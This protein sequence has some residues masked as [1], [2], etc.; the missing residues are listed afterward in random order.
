MFHHTSS[1]T[2]ARK[3]LGGLILPRSNSQ[4]QLLPQRGRGELGPGKKEDVRGG[5]SMRKPT[6]CQLCQVVQCSKCHCGFL[7]CSTGPELRNGAGSS[8]LTG[9]PH[10][11]LLISFLA[12]PKTLGFPHST[13][14]SATWCQWCTLGKEGLGQ[15]EHAQPSGSLQKGAG[16]LRSLPGSL[17]SPRKIFWLFPPSRQQHS[18]TLHI[19]NG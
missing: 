17:L 6:R 9:S 14:E 12:K 18:E 13:S 4:H 19:F 16:T 15:Q 8:L 7:F 2:Q 3:G 10:C 11:P 5:N 1:P